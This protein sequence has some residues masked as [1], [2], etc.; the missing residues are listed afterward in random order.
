MARLK[1]ELPSKLLFTATILVRI[2]DINYGNHVGN[3]ALVGLLHEARMQW[4]RSLNY[5]ELNIEGAAL[6]MGDLAVEFKQQSFYGDALQISIYVGDFS[7]KTVDLYYAVTCHKNEAVQT[8]A[9]AKT[10]M[11]CF[12]YVAKKVIAMPQ[13]FYNLFQ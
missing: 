10:G 8:V 9:V 4:L 13:K 1:L 7:T 2:T 6:I 5:T 12:D 11:V 3:N